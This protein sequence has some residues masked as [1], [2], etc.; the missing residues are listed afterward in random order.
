MSPVPKSKSREDQ[1]VCLPCRK[2]DRGWR[3]GERV[4]ITNAADFSG[5]ELS[6]VLLQY[7]IEQSP[8]G[9]S[10]KIEKGGVNMVVGAKAALDMGLG[11][12]ISDKEWND[13]V[14]KVTE[15]KCE[16]K[17]VLASFDDPADKKHATAI[18]KATRKYERG[19]LLI[20][21]DD[22][23]DGT[24]KLG[25]FLAEA[26]MQELFERMRPAIVRALGGQAKAAFLATP[27]TLQAIRRLGIGSGEGSV[28]NPV[29]RHMR[30]GY[31]LLD[32][33][34][35]QSTIAAMERSLKMEADLA[36]A[37]DKANLTAEEF[38]KL[39]R[40]DIN[41]R[42][43]TACSD[44]TEG[45]IGTYI[46]DL[47]VSLAEAKNKDEAL[48]ICD[49]TAIMSRLQSLRLTEQARAPSM[50]PQSKTKKKMGLAAQEGAA[51]LE[52][53]ID[54]AKQTLQQAADDYLRSTD[55]H[56]RW[57]MKQ[58]DRRDTDGHRSWRMKQSG[59]GDKPD[60]DTFR[61]EKRGG[62]G[63]HS[64]GSRG[65]FARDCPNNRP[66]KPEGMRREKIANAVFANGC[67]GTLD[68]KGMFHKYT[69][70]SHGA[71]A[72]VGSGDEEAA[73]AFPAFQLI[74][75]WSGDV[76][77]AFAFPAFVPGDVDSDG[78]SGGAREGT[79]SSGGEH[80]FASFAFDYPEAPGIDVPQLVR[81]MDTDGEASVWSESSSDSEDTRL[82]DGPEI[83]RVAG[84]DAAVGI[85]EPPGEAGR[86]GD[87]MRQKM[88]V[89]SH[90][91]Y[92]AGG[93]AGCEQASEG[94]AVVPDAK[95]SAEMPTASSDGWVFD[96]RPDQGR[97]LSRYDAC[98]PTV[99]SYEADGERVIGD[100]GGDGVADGNV[101]RVIHR[102][103]KE[104]A[105]TADPN[106]DMLTKAVEHASRVVDRARFGDLLMRLD[107][108]MLGRE[109][110]PVVSRKRPEWSAGAI[111]AVP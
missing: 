74:A 109:D 92:R 45:G 23:G 38:L 2:M 32:E 90:Q 96:Q 28:L 102:H 78:S 17:I 4:V 50:V 19:L 108:W 46:R 72:A 29:L 95:A 37:V 84:S 49:S 82:D 51:G 3:G 61:Q 66:K 99:T 91:Q 22:M 100:Y 8:K 24:N 36:A 16:R 39:Q 56:R 104:D 76:E 110:A 14:I 73:F 101:V 89:P 33:V 77:E 97:K 30:R 52:E 93:D 9:H 6:N 69:E 25:V 26:P 81:W 68:K 11:L 63:C 13:L 43:L 80:K 55:G 65:H 79:P 5:P 75:D 107:R 60:F 88:R 103:G 21:E 70:S 83:I 85:A 58:P 87:S 57:R 41:L 71:F 27:N 64:C 35:G 106:A 20:K 62:M 48:E 31:L 54:Q 40:F 53:I 105:A 15:E 12:T 42:M 18:A 86:Y 98:L 47:G 59:S 10:A 1:V 7:V 44:S 94:D 67:W 111:S 34:E